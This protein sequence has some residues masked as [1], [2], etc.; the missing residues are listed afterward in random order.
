[1]SKLKFD[2]MDFCNGLDFGAR[3]Y[4]HSAAE[5]AQQKFD[6]WLE[7]QPTVWAC[8][9]QAQNTLHWAQPVDATHSARLVD[10]QELKPKV[11]ERHEPNNL[12]ECLH[13]GAKLKPT[14]T[15]E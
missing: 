11:C 4:P 3:L 8:E 9:G 10:I 7:S 1:M 15:A 14:W 13:C 5:M 12:F 2:H 6:S